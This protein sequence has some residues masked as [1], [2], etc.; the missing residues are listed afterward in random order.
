MDVTII[1]PFLSAVMDLFVSMF[2]LSPQ[3]GCPCLLDSKIVHRWEITGLLGVTG[4]F[5]GLVTIRLHKVLANK[6][7][8]KSGITVE[9]EDER[10]ETMHGMIG[11]M[12][13]IV[14]GQAATRITHVSLEISPPA[15]IQGENHLISWPRGIPVICIPFS[16]K[17][18]PF[19]VDVCFAKSK[20]P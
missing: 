6:L 20:K 5:Q 12:T 2:N 7:L 1:N 8:E 4:D 9:T 10:L 19:E 15:V 16:T 17:Y 11:E 3:P 14:A 18:G 13:N